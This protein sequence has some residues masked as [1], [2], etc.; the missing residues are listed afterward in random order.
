MTKWHQVF[1]IEKDNGKGVKIVTTVSV[2]EEY[3]D[4]SPLIKSMSQ[5]M[6]IKA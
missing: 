1:K 4:L 3:S 6:G 2:A 5:A